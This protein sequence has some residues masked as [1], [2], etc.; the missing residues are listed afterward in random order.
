[1]DDSALFSSSPV[2]VPDSFPHNDG[3]RPGTPR[4]PTGRTPQQPEQPP[5][6]DAEE[7]RDAALQRELD[8]VRKINET[9]EGVIGTLERSRKDMG[10]VSHTVA[11]ASALLSTWTRLLSQTEHNQRL[12]LNPHWQGATQ[13]LL[14]VEAEAAQRQQ[15][16][17]RRAAEAQRRRDEAQRKAEDEERRRL[18]AAAPSS[19]SSSTTR[20][21]RGGGFLRGSGVRGGR[22]G[23]SRGVIGY[24]VSGTARGSSRAGTVGVG[25]SSSR[26]GRVGGSSSTASTDAGTASHTSTCR[27]GSNIGRGFN[28][29]RGTRAGGRGVR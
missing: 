5:A 3:D 18:L 27:S 10:T 22:A 12:L 13:D 1:M 20:G 29:T 2:Q 25:T 6:Y 7:L 19:S 15:Q 24:G 9:I 28:T 11:N 16:A 14:A 26:Y 8:G 17:E 4:T 23:G 21:G